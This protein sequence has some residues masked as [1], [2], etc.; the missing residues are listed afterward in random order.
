MKLAF[1]DDY[2]LGVVK[3]DA[4]HDV[5]AVVR[6]IPHVGPGDLISSLI[7]RFG[8]YRGGLE[9]AATGAGTPAG[10]RPHPAA[11]AQAGQHRLHGGELHGKRHSGEARAA[12]CV[13]QGGNSD[14][15]AR[16][17][18]WCCPTCRQRSS[19]ARPKWPW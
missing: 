14:H 15:R 1:F 19:R 3:G 6:D 17:T 12:Q 11:A 7:A 4:I 2:R 10:K 9:A 5:S 18:P 8:D 13:P 16:A